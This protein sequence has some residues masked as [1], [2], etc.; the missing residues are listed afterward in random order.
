MG[1]KRGP[2]RE[3]E[4]GMKEKKERE[5]REREGGME[6]KKEREGEKGKMGWKK[7]RERLRGEKGTKQGRGKQL[8]E[9]W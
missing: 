8:S 6:R 9:E 5:R 7:K 4:D 2:G 3:R 1:W